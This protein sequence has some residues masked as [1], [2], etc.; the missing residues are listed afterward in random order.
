M[1][2]GPATT[3]PEYTSHGSGGVQVRRFEDGEWHT[4]RMP[5]REASVEEIQR[6]LEARPG[7]S[8]YATED[9]A[10]IVV[11]V[12]AM[13]AWIVPPEELARVDD[14]GPLEL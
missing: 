6:L 8:I 1:S 7:L 12:D 11:D 2:G 14:Y 5:L 13:D 9:G 10:R 4:Y 3:L